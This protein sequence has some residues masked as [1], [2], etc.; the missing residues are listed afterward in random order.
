V[1]CTE[2]RRSDDHR[3]KSLLPVCSR[4]KTWSQKAEQQDM[5]NISC[6]QDWSIENDS[7]SNN[8]LS[9]RARKSGP[10]NMDAAVWKL[11]ITNHIRVFLQLQAALCCTLLDFY[12]RNTFLGGIRLF[13]FN[14]IINFCYFTNASDS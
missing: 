3:D 7:R 8:S 6:S 10:A 13:F 12:W 5:P 11:V 9:T 2:C 14:A 1:S 4:V